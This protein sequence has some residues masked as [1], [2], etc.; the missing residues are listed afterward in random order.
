[1]QVESSGI[2]TFNKFFENKEGILGPEAVERFIDA[3]GLLCAA[4]DC[5]LA[6]RCCPPLAIKRVSVLFVQ[7][8][9][10]PIQL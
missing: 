3:G 1:M 5:A 9:C 4:A 6:N 8:R 10:A 7:G 2:I